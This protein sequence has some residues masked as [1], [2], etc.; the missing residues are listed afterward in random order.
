MTG[1]RRQ[2]AV[3]RDAS[4][5]GNGWLALSDDDLLFA[6]RSSCPSGHDADGRLLEVV[7]SARHFFI[8]QEAAK[9]RATTGTR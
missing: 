7:R 5:V 3:V 6:H 9:T 2:P 4:G 1:E 8:R